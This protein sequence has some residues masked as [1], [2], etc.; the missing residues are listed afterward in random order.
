MNQ[1]LSYAGGDVIKDVRC[2]KQNTHVSAMFVVLTTIFLLL[3]STKFILEFL[4]SVLM[5][6]D[7]SSSFPLESRQE[8]VPILKVSGLHRR[9]LPLE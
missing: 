3:N 2:E 7:K 9:P 8:D 4:N 6:K 1:A 5:K